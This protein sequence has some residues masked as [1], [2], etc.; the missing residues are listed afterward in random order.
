MSDNYVDPELEEMLRRRAQQESRR[1]I[2]E[3]QKRAELEAKKE[4]IL[5]VILTP[6]ARLRL[7]NVKLVKPDIATS[8]ED[9]LIALAQTGRIKTP[10]G[11]DELKEILSQIADQNKRDYKIQIRERGWK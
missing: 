5:R 11:D 8:L 4:A 3:Q 2:E 6:E 7:N 1:N 10:I 9:Q